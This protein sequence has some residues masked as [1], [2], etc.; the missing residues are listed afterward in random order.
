MVF[1]D[2]VEHLS[3]GRQRHIRVSQLAR[4]RPNGLWRAKRE[5][6]PRLRV[7]AIETPA[8]V[9][10]EEHSVAAGRHQVGATAVLVHARAA[11]EPLWRYVGSL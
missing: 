4:V 6:V 11:A 10:D 2:G 7:L 8:V 9:I 5:A 1:H 3:I